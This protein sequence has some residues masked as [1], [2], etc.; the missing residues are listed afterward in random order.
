MYLVNQAKDKFV[1]SKHDEIGYNYQLSN[2]NAAVGCAQLENIHTLIKKRKKIFQTYKNEFFL[3]KEFTICDTPIDAYSN[4]WLTILKVKNK[5]LIDK[6]IHNLK[7]NNIE[8]RPLWILNH[9]QKQFKKYY[10]FDIKLANKLYS[11]C[12]CLP[13]SPNLNVSDI[14]KISNLIKNT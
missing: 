3:S 7:K 1:Y 12:L 8:T 6:I 9:K 14:V 10:S 2:L 13:S 5:I 4:N 11:T